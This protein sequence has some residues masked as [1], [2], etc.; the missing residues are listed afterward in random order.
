MRPRGDVRMA[1]VTA[2]QTGPAYPAALAERVGLDVS[3]VREALNN[4][5]RGGETRVVGDERVPGSN[6][7]ARVFELVDGSLATAPSISWDLID[8]WSRWPAQ[9]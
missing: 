1:L 4:M 9:Q 2:L 8:C 3:C 7:P 5:R 6:R